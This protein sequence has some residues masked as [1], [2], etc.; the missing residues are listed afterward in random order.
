MVLIGWSPFCHPMNDN[1]Y[2]YESPERLVNDIFIK[3]ILDPKISF[4]NWMN[5]PRWEVSDFSGLFYGK[6]KKE[7]LKYILLQ[8]KLDQFDYK[9]KDA[10]IPEQYML[11]HRC[12]PLTGFTVKPASVNVKYQYISDKDVVA[13]VHYKLPATSKTDRKFDDSI[14]I[15][16]LEKIDNKWMISHIR[17]DN[18]TMIK[19]LKIKQ[20]WIKEALRAIN[21]NKEE[22]LI[23]RYYERYPNPENIPNLE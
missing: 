16:S 21:S 14:I 18:L 6:L 5:N 13:S 2:V 12:H 9:I 23:K 1:T 3:Q 15:V 10:V 20:K 17:Y 19:F 7:A 4:G 11:T 8:K 22:D